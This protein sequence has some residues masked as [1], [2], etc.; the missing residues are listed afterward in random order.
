MQQHRV[1]AEQHSCFA[2]HK[3]LAI[4]LAETAESMSLTKAPHLMTA[5][6]MAHLWHP[7]LLGAP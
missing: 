7:Q 1:F 6:A 3:T 2:K 4:S 5:M